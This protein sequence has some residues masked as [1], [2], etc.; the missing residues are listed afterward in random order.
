MT[1]VQEL[2]RDA[3]TLPGESAIRDAEI[4]LCHCLGKPRSWLYTW[5][6][7]EISGADLEKYHALLARRSRG[8][9]VAYLTGR[10]EFWSLDL[11]V[12]PS[13]LI[14]RPETETLVAWALELPLAAE[15]AVLD[16][17]T[18]TGAIALALAQENPRWQV[19]GVDR[20]DAAVELARH[21]AVANGL[22]AVELQCSD[23][24]QQLPGRRF[25]LIVSNPPYIEAGDP[26][27]SLGDVRHEPR[28][29]LVA[30]DDGLADLAHIVTAA[31]A[32]LAEDGWLLLEHGHEQGARVRQLLQDRGFSGV[33]T[34]CDLA[35]LERVSGGLWRAQ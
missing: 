29:A 12:N 6:E 13:T 27:L 15:A 34:R 2:L 20:C 25:Q 28:S 16:L 24:F 30:Q 32:H 35:G 33:Q 1:R 8:E 26:H 22:P 14:P 9:P 10:R 4:L 7:A 5:P 19:T 18:G 11:R 17:G 21:N 3:R 23:W 31:P